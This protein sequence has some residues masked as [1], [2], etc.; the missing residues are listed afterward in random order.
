MN[1]DTIDYLI[2]KFTELLIQQ[3]YKD[4]EKG[5]AYIKKVD[6]YSDLIRL[7]KEVKDGTIN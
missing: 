6:V 1:D 2:Q 5:T 4:K 7:L 3:K